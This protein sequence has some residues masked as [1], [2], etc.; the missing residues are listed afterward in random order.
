V[1]PRLDA[2]PYLGAGIGL[3][4]FTAISPVRFD[5]A[6]PLD[7]HSKGDSPVQVY[8]SLGQAF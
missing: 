4:Y 7:P 2:K 1:L 3:R 6:T 8:V 5:I